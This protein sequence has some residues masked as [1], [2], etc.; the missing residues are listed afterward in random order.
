MQ[1]K[2]WLKKNAKIVTIYENVVALYYF[3]LAH[4]NA[5]KGKRKISKNNI[6]QIKRYKG[7]HKGQRCFIVGTGPSLNVNDLDMIKNEISFTVNTGYKAYAK[8]DWRANYYVTMDDS[9][10][11]ADFLIE[12]I[13]GNHK[14]EGV[15][16]DAL[17]KA[18]IDEKVV[19]KLPTSA[20]NVFLFNTVWNRMWPKLFP[21]AQFSND[22][23]KK[24]YCG[25][26]VVYACIQIAAYMGFSEIYLLGVDCDYD[27][28]VTHSEL[29]SYSISEQ[30]K[31]RA[32]N[33][34]VL[35][36]SQFNVL[37]K[38]ISQYNVK[39]YNATRGGALEAFP[40]VRLEEVFMSPMKSI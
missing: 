6:E 17:S 3:F 15:F 36:R 10:K 40:R 8:T 37:A 12:A 25:K 30:D 31:K 1:M 28:K 16:C 7:I 38:N 21:I 18:C 2:R 26:T 29:A 23:S 24:I 14:Y 35:M 5:I 22:I 39:V 13:S 4:I 11:A 27:K 34:G 9:Q 20:A 33:S 19:T 32:I